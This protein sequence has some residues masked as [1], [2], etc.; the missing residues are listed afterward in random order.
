[1]KYLFSLLYLMALGLVL[2]AQNTSAFRQDGGV[3]ADPLERTSVSPIHRMAFGYE[4][5]AAF[6]GELDD[7]ILHTGKFLLP[8]LENDQATAGLSV[9][10]RFNP[11]NIS[12]G[13]FDGNGIQGTL[14]P[15][16]RWG[17][18][19]VHGGLT[20]QFDFATATPSVIS[21][22]AGFEFQIPNLYNG[23]TG[24]IGANVHKNSEF[25]GVGFE[26]LGTINVGP[27]AGFMARYQYYS[28]NAKGEWA[29]GAVGAI[30]AQSFR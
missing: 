9:I 6:A 14:A 21:G 13:F 24:S 19:I 2:S 27:A 28:G 15:W 17:N 22:F 3:H 12:E 30:S 1:M 16:K 29:L 20:G 18:T 10:S 23:Y 4:V 11:R 8:V 25:S 5:T 7:R 26:L